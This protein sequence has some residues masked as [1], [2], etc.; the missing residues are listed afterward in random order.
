[1]FLIEPCI[2][3]LSHTYEAVRNNKILLPCSFCT[4]GR[5]MVYASGLRARRFT[6]NEGVG[7]VGAAK[8]WF[9]FG[10]DLV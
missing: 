2:G 9:I 6:R 7:H 1:M 10:K 3:E 5:V 4:F 8:L